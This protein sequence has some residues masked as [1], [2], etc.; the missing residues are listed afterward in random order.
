[1]PSADE[2]TPAMSLEDKIKNR[3]IKDEGNKGS[4]GGKNMGPDAGR[5]GFGSEGKNKTEE[6][7][8]E[9]PQAEL[10]SAQSES[11]EISS[12]RWPVKIRQ[13]YE[14]VGITD[15]GAQAELA[16]EIGIT[17]ISNADESAYKAVVTQLRKL[18]QS[19]KQD[20]TGA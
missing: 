4:A 12:P 11:N 9:K 3:E 7:K 6:K 1:M 17:D 15:M 2:M 18:E 13:A 20:P 16:G 14:N 10:W 5:D 19:G 8:E